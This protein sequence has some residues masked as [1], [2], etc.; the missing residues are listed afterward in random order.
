[1]FVGDDV[2]SEHFFFLFF[3]LAWAF[4]GFFLSFFY[5]TYLLTLFI[6]KPFRG[7]CCYFGIIVVVVDR[8][9]LISYLL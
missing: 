2:L 6:L 5:L 3:F 4:G 7:R 1:M 9:F 8:L